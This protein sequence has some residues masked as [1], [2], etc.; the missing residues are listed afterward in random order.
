MAV[1]TVRSFEE[2]RRHDRADLRQHSRHRGGLSSASYVHDLK[3]WRHLHN[4]A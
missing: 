1:N 2:L 4:A 3:K